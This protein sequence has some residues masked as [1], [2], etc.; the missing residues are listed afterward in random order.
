MDY[1][2]AQLGSLTP[3]DRIAANPNPFA[4]RS[5]HFAT[6]YTYT[7]GPLLFENRSSAQSTPLTIDRVNVSG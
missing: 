7:G 1:L 4:T 6:L 3:G 2:P 5:I